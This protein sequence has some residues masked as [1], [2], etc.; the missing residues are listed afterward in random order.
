MKS[1]VQRHGQ[2][3]FQSAITAT[4]Y[5]VLAQHKSGHPCDCPEEGNNTDE[6]FFSTYCVQS[7]ELSPLCGLSQN[8][9][10]PQVGAVLAFH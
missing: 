4:I 7:P 9:T 2:R 5:C 8:F 3:A 6:H 10:P 1:R